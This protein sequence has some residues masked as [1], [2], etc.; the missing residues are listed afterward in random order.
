[1]RRSYPVLLLLAA[2]F[3]LLF[4]APG[5]GPDPSDPPQSQAVKDFDNS[6]LSDWN[7][8]FL[9]VERDAQG[10]RP[11]PAARA[12]A[13]IGLATYE[14]CAPGMSE[15]QSLAAL[16]PALLL[17]TADASAEYYWPEVVNAAYAALMKHFFPNVNPSVTQDIIALETYFDDKYQANVS[18]DIWLASRARGEAV[19]EAIWQWSASDPNG[20][21]LYLDPFQGYDWQSHFGQ[22]GNWTPSF[23]GP[24]KPMFGTFGAVRTFALPAAARLCQAPLPFSEDP[25]SVMMA[26]AEEVFTQDGNDPLLMA[27]ALRW[28]NDFL[29]ATYSHGSRW[30]AVANRVYKIE[31]ADLEKALVVNAK[32]GLALNDAAVGCFYSKYHYNMEVPETYIQRNLDPNW[33]PHLDNPVTGDLGITPSFPAFPSAYATFAAAAAAALESE[34]GSGYPFTDTT[35]DPAFGQPATYN[36]FAE[37]AEECGISRIILG[38]DWRMGVQEGIHF[39][40]KIG[41][42]VNLLP[43]Q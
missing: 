31:S 20:H 36:S 37:M 35:A 26:Q 34:F 1:M 8:L 40:K 9:Q 42:H 11:C 13:Y 22:A 6:V 23:P 16:Y 32:L 39:G 24:G 25:N 10:Y 43:W 2:A 21:N 7:T 19:A 38:A 29:H 12:L 28:N 5:C 41:Q 17:P 4:F 33:K 27:T 14:A 30:L 18:P 15:H 3:S